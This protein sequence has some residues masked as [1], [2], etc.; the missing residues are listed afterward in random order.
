MPKKP[1]TISSRPRPTIPNIGGDDAHPELVA[2]LDVEEL[3]RRE[4]ARE[5]RERADHGL[6]DDAVAELRTSKNL[7][8]A[9]SAT[10]SSAA[11]ASTRAGL[12]TRLNELTSDSPKAPSAADRQGQ[13]RAGELASVAVSTV[14]SPM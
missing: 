13:R 3:V 12:I 9:P 5:G 2:D 8:S 1:S 4:R 7:L 11:K 6:D 14:T 10:P